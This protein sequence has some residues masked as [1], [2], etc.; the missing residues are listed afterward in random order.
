[1]YVL[2]RFETK[3]FKLKKVSEDFDELFSKEYLLFGQNYILLHLVFD[4]RNYR[5]QTPSRY[6]NCLYTGS[7]AIFYVYK[8]IAL[9]RYCITKTLQRYWTLCEAYTTVLN[10]IIYRCVLGQAA[11]KWL[12]VVH[13][14][15]DLLFKDHQV[16]PTL[17]TTTNDE[18]KFVYNTVIRARLCLQC[19]RFAQTGTKTELHS[20]RAYC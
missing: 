17:K 18:K 8:L 6:D 3:R 16:F 19:E 2:S 11:G 7:V 5:L 14:T 9:L 1:M 10:E 20:R 4:F 13:L 12:K 15:C